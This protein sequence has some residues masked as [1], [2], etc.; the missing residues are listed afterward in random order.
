MS[1]AGGTVR[2]WAAGA[3]TGPRRPVPSTG[4][5]AGCACA[6]AGAALCGGVGFLSVQDLPACWTDAPPGPPLSEALGGR[7][8]TPQGRGLD[9]EADPEQ[10]NLAVPSRSQAWVWRLQL[11]VVGLC[12]WAL[13]VGGRGD[14]QAIIA[15]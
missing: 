1:K 13:S 3:A 7:G 12:P 8:Q 15:L 2:P 11:L 14:G 4:V 10:L 6:P 9:R 5:L